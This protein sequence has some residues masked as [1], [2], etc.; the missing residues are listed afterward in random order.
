VRRIGPIFYTAGGIA[1]FNP[2]G[3]IASLYDKMQ[4]YNSISHAW[5]VDP[6]PMPASTAGQLADGAQCTDGT[7]VY[8]INGI[9]KQ[10]LY[11]RL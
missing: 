5:T 7:R 1:A 6:Q 11:S 10:F 2:D 9:D 4:I 8:F 3:S